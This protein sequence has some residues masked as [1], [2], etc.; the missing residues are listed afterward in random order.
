MHSMHSMHLVG[1][2]R[3][4]I[5]LRA[6]DLCLL[7]A[8]AMFSCSQGTSVECNAVQPISTAVTPVI[9]KSA[10]RPSTRKTPNRPQ[11]VALQSDPIPASSAKVPHCLSVTA[12]T[13]VCRQTA[14]LLTAVWTFR[15]FCYPAAAPVH[16]APAAA[17]VHGA[18]AAADTTLHLL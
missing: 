13:M 15:Q 8:N 14:L 3:L 6:T 2:S 16:G 17:P 5:D 11:P 12:S 9:P 7:V 18:P 10:N 1:P 4:L